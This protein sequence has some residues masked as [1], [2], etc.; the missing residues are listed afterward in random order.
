MC[1]WQKVILLGLIAAATGARA[2]APYSFACAEDAHVEAA[3]KQAVDSAAQAFAEA[4]FGTEPSSA[5]DLLTQEGQASMSREQMGGPAEAALRQLAPK[6]FAVQHTYL[7][8]MKGSSPGRVVCAM[9]LTKPEGGESVATKSVP[10]QAHVLLT[11]ETINNQWTLAVWLIPEQGKWRV[12][13]YWVGVSSYGHLDS[14]DLLA[15]A[16]AQSKL[17]HNFN[18]TMLYA[19]AKEASFRGANFETG[20]S[21]SIA[22]DTSHLDLP[23]GLRGPAP[24][25]WKNGDATYKILRIGPLCIANKL[26]IV[27]A[28][29][30]VPWQSNEQVESWNRRLLAYFKG[31]YP[32]YATS[33]S[34]IVVRAMEQGTNRG[35]GTVEETAPSAVTH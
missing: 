24:F 34:G 32:E 18:A 17:G 27:V 10:E 12:Q 31:Q 35:Y 4:A 5:F 29:E 6:T 2:Q 1:K 23:S 21:Q 26:Y 22:E 28:H 15:L 11:G 19:A 8:D 25:L 9:D 30:V 16:R 14:M 20:I 13:S 3:K 7:I 33:F